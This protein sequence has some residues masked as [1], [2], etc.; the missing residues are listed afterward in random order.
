MLLET[1]A[2]DRLATKRLEGLPDYVEALVK[3]DERPAT[4]LAQHKLADGAQFALHQHELV[5]LPGISLDGADDDGP[6]WLRIERLQRTVP[7]Q[8]QEDCC[9]WIE[10]S[11]DPTKPPAIRELRHLRVTKD[12]KDDLLLTETVR[13]EDVAPAL[14]GPTKDEL[15][16]RILMLCSALKTEW[17]S[18]QFWRTTVSPRGFNGPKP[19]SQGADRSPSINAYS[20]L[21]NGCCS[22]ADRSLRSLSG[23]LD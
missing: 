17:N 18:E 2:E 23:V 14:K 16:V 5:G 10:V 15:P 4:H 1:T 8:P 13:P 22:R 6:I 7:P 11:N 3:L 9:A 19:R 20:R 21:L 12:E